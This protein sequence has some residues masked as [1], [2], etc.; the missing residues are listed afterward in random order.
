[1]MTD[2]KIIESALLYEL[3]LFP[4]ALF[5]DKGIIRKSKKSE[6]YVVLKSSSFRL[7]DLTGCLFVVDESFLLHKVLWNNKKT[8]REIFAAYK[9]YIFNHFNNT[10]FITFDGYEENFCNVKSYGRFRRLSK[11]VAPEITFNLEMKLT[12][13]K[14][15]FSK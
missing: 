7:S 15:I 2:P 9:A 1:M 12:E 13:K 10:T 14:N 11:K 6:L 5:D 4:I 8:I 3:A